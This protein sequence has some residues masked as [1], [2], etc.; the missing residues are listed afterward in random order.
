MAVPLKKFF[1]ESFFYGKRLELKG[2]FCGNMQSREDKKAFKTYF[3]GPLSELEVWLK[4]MPFACC[5]LFYKREF[6]LN[7]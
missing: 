5:A 6:D 2:I 7:L 4:K 3:C 1:F